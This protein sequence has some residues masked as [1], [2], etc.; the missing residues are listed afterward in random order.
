MA[1]SENFLVITRRQSPLII[2]EQLGLYDAMGLM[3][4]APGNLPP[5]NWW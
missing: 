4:V 2:I 3:L 1:R 5:S